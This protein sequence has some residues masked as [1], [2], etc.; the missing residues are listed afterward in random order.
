MGYC[1]LHPLTP[2]LIFKTFYT[3][4]IELIIE[5]KKDIRIKCYILLEID[6]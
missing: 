2:L 1:V 6:K 3:N 5:Y 4:I